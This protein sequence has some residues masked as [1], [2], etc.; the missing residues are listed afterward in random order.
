MK[1]HELEYK[2]IIFV[3]KRIKNEKFKNLNLIL[4]F[5]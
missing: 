2:V 3:N 5:Q 4:Y 1:N